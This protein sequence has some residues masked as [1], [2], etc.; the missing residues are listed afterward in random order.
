[1]CFCTCLPQVL[2]ETPSYA[3]A[4]GRGSGGATRKN[5]V[6]ACLRPLTVAEAHAVSSRSRALPAAAQAELL[7]DQDP[8][9]QAVVKMLPCQYGLVNACPAAS[10]PVHESYPLRPRPHSTLQL[11]SDDCQGGIY[12]PCTSSAR[13][14]VCCASWKTSSPR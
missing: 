8:K 11:L 2:P 10:V 12:F 14:S 13:N 1:M 9:P 4:Q 6:Q 7:C 3:S 5:R